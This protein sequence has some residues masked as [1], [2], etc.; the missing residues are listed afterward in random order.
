MRIDLHC[1]SKYSLD[2]SFEPELLIKQ[3]IKLNLDGVCFTE[4]DSLEASWPVTEIKVP[5]G[6]YVFRGLEISTDKGHL[7]VYGLKDDSWNTWYMN[8][9]PDAQAVIKKVRLM[10]GVCA[11]A[12]PFRP[13]DS[14]AGELLRMDNFD[15]V[16]THNGRDS[17][18]MNRKALG[19]S[20]ILGLPSIGGSD[21][22]HKWQVGRAYTLFKNPVYTSEALADEIRKGNCQGEMGKILN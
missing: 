18:D 20:R 1:H 10:G 22:H 16:E 14:F 13:C 15:A 2:N 8:S 17:P 9:Y 12:H 21:C 5:E 11:P 3:A 6:F 7:L 4:H 19:T